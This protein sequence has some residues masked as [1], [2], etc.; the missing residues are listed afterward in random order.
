MVHALPEIYSSSGLVESY[1]SDFSLKNHWLKKSEFWSQEVS[2][3]MGASVQCILWHS[4][5]CVVFRYFCS[6]PG[7]Y[8]AISNS[9]KFCIVEACR[10][11]WRG[12]MGL[13]FLL[14][15]F[16]RYLE[17]ENWRW[18]IFFKCVSKTLTLRVQYVDIDFIMYYKA[19]STYSKIKQGLWY[20][21]PS[22][23]P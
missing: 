2:H 12:T 20:Q 5:C 16:T 13:N 4:D 8:H 9:F 19:L 7:G 22:I 11:Q 1:V 14:W 6:V 21:Y 10:V 17:R 18:E 3:N 23:L 15:L